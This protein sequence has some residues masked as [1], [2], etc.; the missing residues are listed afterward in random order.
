MVCADGFRVWRSFRNW[1]NHSGI[2]STSAASVFASP[3]TEGRAQAE[4]RRSGT[5]LTLTDKRWIIDLIHQTWGNRCRTVSFPLRNAVRG[6]T[7]AEL[8]AA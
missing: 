4:S 3:R 5:A 7:V 6:Y 8:T 2:G 1:E